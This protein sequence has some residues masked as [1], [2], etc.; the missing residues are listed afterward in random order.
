MAVPGAEAEGRLVPVAVERVPVAE[1]VGHHMLP[2]LARRPALR[3]VEGAE[4][5]EAA[6]AGLVLLAVEDVP[7]AEAAVRLVPL[8]AEEL[9][10]ILVEAAVGVH[11]ESVR[12]AVGVEVLGAAAGLVPLAAADVWA[13]VVQVSAVVTL[14]QSVALRPSVIRTFLRE[15]PVSLRALPDI[16]PRAS[17]RGL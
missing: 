2:R 16:P 14:R 8:S 10:R 3:A 12:L 11:R 1:E 6:A 5:R 17:V 9:W 15:L 4:V 7:V 13:A